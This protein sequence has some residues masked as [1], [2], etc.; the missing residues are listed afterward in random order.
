M[1][2]DTEAAPSRQS[3]RRGRGLRVAYVYRTFSEVGSIPSLYRRL[4][5]TLSH[6]VDL[7]LMCSRRGRATTD[8][9]LKFHDVE[10]LLAGDGRFRYAIECATFAARAASAARRTREAF[11]LVHSE[12]FALPR[13]DLVT[14]HAVR[15]AEIER[16]FTQIESRATFRKRLP[17][18]VRPQAAVVLAIERRL[19]AHPAPLCIVPSAQIKRDLEHF[20]DVPSELVRVIPYGIDAEGLQ[21]DEPE[22]RARRADFGVSDD[23]LVVLFVGDSFLRKGLA[24]AIEG[25]AASRVRP[26]L[27]VIGGDD[28]SR[29]AQLA[30]RLGVAQ[31]VRFLGRRSPSDVASF[32]SAA[33]VLL[34][35]SRND[36]WGL[37]PI[38]AMVSGRVPV[39]SSF[40]GA[41]EV[42][43][44]GTNG[45]VL[46][47]AG[48]AT[49]I[50]SLLDGPLSDAATRQALGSRAAL[51]AQ[52][53]AW[54]NVYPRLLD[55]HYDAHEL[56]QSRRRAA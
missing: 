26:E 54:P 33:D 4:A 20:H 38:E 25:V 34:L 7:T 36:A 1:S 16:Y 48:E 11:D 45:Y 46:R 24:T 23:T 51:D 37:P 35:P 43:K 15:A 30:A 3:E 31:Q 41:S 10:P 2:L 49:E 6:D 8:A 12:G 56:L 44:H 27:W 47:S 21:F 28:A 42:I 29:Y 5:E 40:T 18:I 52:E 32:Y 50:A 17:N 39:V 19:F 9:P 53:F 13:A 55:A 14:V 22:R